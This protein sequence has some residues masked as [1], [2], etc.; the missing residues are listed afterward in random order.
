MP[1]S[2]RPRRSAP[3]SP[4]VFRKPSWRRR[5]AIRAARKYLQWLFFGPSCIEPAMIQIFTK[6]E[7]PSS[8]RRGATRTQVFDVLDKA[9]EK[10]PWILG[11]RL[12]RR[13]HRDRL[14]AEFCGAAV[15]DGAVAA[16]L[17][18]YI[19]ALHGAAGVPARGEDRGGM[20][21]ALHAVRQS[22]RDPR[23][24]AASER[25]V[26]A[27]AR[28]DDCCHHAV[29]A[30]LVRPRH[31]DD[32]VAGIDEMDL[33][34]DAAGQI[35]QQIKRGAA[36]LVERDAAAAAANASAGTR[37]CARIADAGAGQR[38]DRAGRNR[39]DA[40]AAARRNRPRGSAPKP[41]APPWPRPS[42]C[43]SASRA[44]S[45]RRSA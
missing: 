40:D 1:R 18:C 32:V 14:G 35:R 20:N 25:M 24:M 9:L 43:S 13:R 5:S 3:M 6:L 42:R 19:D 29:A 44:S 4:S 36:E 16:V 17:R 38:A 37:T 21:P 15:Q 45:R 23:G 34:G 12:L 10:G 27:C 28:H 8:R 31:R 33:A 41:P 22:G 7:V 39:V 26:A 11:E 2:P 30:Q